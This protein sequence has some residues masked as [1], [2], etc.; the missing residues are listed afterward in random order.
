MKYVKWMKKELVKLNGTAM[1][2]RAEMDRNNRD[3]QPDI[4]AAENL[5]LQQKLNAAADDARKD[6][7]STLDL[8]TRAVEKWAAPDGDAVDKADLVLLNGSF[9]LSARDLHTLLVKHQDSGMMTNAIKKYAKD[10]GVMLDYVPNSEDKMFAYESFANSANAMIAD[11]V[12]SIG[13]GVDPIVL[14]EWGKQDNISQRMERVLYGIT[15][16]E[17]VPQEKVAFDFGFKSLPGRN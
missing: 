4:A 12:H 7:A 13:L 6:I 3:F 17:I 9:N 8:A 5:K 14:S 11:I 1:K 15:E 10:H 2:I 16:P